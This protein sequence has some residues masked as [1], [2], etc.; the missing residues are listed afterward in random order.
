M[1]KEKKKYNT[2]DMREASFSKETQGKYNIQT[3]KELKD[4]MAFSSMKFSAD[5]EKL[6]KNLNK[7]GFFE[8]FVKF[9]FR[10]TYN[11]TYDRGATDAVSISRN[12][13]SPS[14]TTKI[15]KTKTKNQE[16]NEP[17]KVE[18]TT[19]IRKIIEESKKE[20]IANESSL[21][22]IE[23]NNKKN[24][25]KNKP[26]SNE[27]DIHKTANDR[28][29]KAGN[30]DDNIIFKDAKENNSEEEY[31]LDDEFNKRAMKVKKK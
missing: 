20:K 4:S 7:L 27:D 1:K 17:K 6:Y 9:F 19:E 18:K 24:K 23:I 5:D 13:N 12:L 26:F 29:A 2:K 28:F 8:K 11:K 3:K 10:G 15:S 31:S 30:L 25:L 22:R 16:T 21:T 14:P